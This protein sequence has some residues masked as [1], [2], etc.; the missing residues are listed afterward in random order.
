MSYFYS[1]SYCQCFQQTPLS[2]SFS[3][4][5]DASYA[6]YSY[7]ERPELPNRTSTQYLSDLI[8]WTFKPVFFEAGRSKRVV[9][10]T[11]VPYVIV[12]SYGYAPRDKKQI[13]EVS[14]SLTS[15]DADRPNQRTATLFLLHGSSLCLVISAAGFRYPWFDFRQARDFFFFAGS[16]MF[17]YPNHA[18]SGPG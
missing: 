15:S 10:S 7:V 6:I 11:L 1:G 12:T 8:L 18:P 2:G 16:Q 5:Y 13:L 14:V 9:T 17:L 4:S 3:R